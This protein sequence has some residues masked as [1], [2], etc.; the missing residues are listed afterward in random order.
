MD[1]ESRN[2][3]SLH[4][5]PWPD[6]LVLHTICIITSHL[7]QES[8]CNSCSTWFF[9]WLMLWNIVYLYPVPGLY[10][11]FPLYHW[12]PLQPWVRCPTLGH[13]SMSWI[14]LV[15]GTDPTRLHSF[16]F[17]C[18]RAA[19]KWT[20]PCFTSSHHRKDRVKIRGWMYVISLQLMNIVY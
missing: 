3:F 20:V 5:H 11:P 14:Y 6:S 17:P 1:G 7:P 8:S 10:L 13:V 18:R 16:P 19:E 12:L 15:H 4:Q 2:D 9:S